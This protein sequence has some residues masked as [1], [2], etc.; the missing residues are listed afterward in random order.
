MIK[1]IG[2]IILKYNPE[3]RYKNRLGFPLTPEDEERMFLMCVS[4]ARFM[5]KY[6]KGSEPYGMSDTEIHQVK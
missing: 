5:L 1:R 3:Q 4:A 2:N 6:G